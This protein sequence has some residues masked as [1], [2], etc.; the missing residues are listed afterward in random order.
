MR[1][2]REQGWRQPLVVRRLC[3]ACTDCSGAP[4]RLLHQ[5]RSAPSLAPTTRPIQANSGAGAGAPQNEKGEEE[6]I[7]LFEFLF[8]N[9][10]LF[11]SGIH[12]LQGEAL[13]QRSIAPLL[14]I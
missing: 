3:V 14:R 11:A 2:F 4:P 6:T 9:S 1:E 10:L 12:G 8:P 5:E 13:L 7:P